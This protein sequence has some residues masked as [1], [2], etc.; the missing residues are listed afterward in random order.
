MVAPGPE[1]A[2]PQRDMVAGMRTAVV[3]GAGSGF[4]RAIAAE[5]RRRS[6]R[7]WA[8]DLDAEAAARTA[9]EIGDGAE[10]AGLDVSDESVCRALAERVAE[11]GSLDLW[12]NNTGV[13]STGLSWEVEEAARG[14][15][16]RVNTEGT[17]NGTVAALT[18]MVPA[19]R[20][21]V[22]NIV[23]LAGVVAAPGESPTRR[24][25][26][27]RWPSP[28]ARSTTFAAPATPGSS[29]RPSA[30]T[31]PG[32][33][34]SPTGSTTSTPPAPSP[35]ARRRAAAP[36]P[37]PPPDDPAAPGPALGRK[38]PPAALQ[39][40]DRVRPLALTLPAGRRQVRLCGRR[41][42]RGPEPAP[43]W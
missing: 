16:L 40:P 24:A 2:K 34:C 13:L 4:G 21:H 18:Q 43:R 38:A 26:T 28:S 35:L 22:I 23:S 3:T 30:R 12:V 10:S 42:L 36:Q 11:S 17:M 9:A 1:S 25:S 14:T 20:G 37:L 8:T 15:M 31:A 33:R 5:L 39:A 7:V 27:R 32:R 6:Y 29:S 19:G 41:R